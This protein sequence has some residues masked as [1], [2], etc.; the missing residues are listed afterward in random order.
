MSEQ[1][2]IDCPCTNTV[3]ARHGRCDEC[4]TFHHNHPDPAKRQTSCERRGLA[5]PQ[6]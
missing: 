6:Q 2:K 1:N 4:R 3:C 5:K